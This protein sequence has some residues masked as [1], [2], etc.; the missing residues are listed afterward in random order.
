MTLAL[1]ALVAAM[2]SA[3]EPRRILLVAGGDSHGY[4]AH[5]HGAGFR[6]LAE[7]LNA[8]VPGLQATVAESWPQDSTLL[9][10][11]DALAFYG[12]GGAGSLV[13]SHLDELRRQVARG[14][15]VA[16][17]H[18]ALDVPGA[19][20]PGGL[21]EWSGGYYETHWSVN[22][23]WTA[24]FSTFPEHPVTRGVRPFALADE[25]YYNMRFVQNMTGV[26]PVLTALP[27]DSTRAG[28]DGPYSGNPAV[29]ARRGIPEHLAWVYER[30]DGGRSFG[31]TGGHSHWNWAQDDV[32]RLVLNALTWLAGVEVPAGGITSA[33]PSLDHLVA[34][35]R[36]PAPQ[37][38]DR[39]GV[40]RLLAQWRDPS[41]GSGKP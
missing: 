20:A 3:A 13:S 8:N 16:L 36:K 24:T 1:C 4:G 38:W 21:L 31:F 23:F 30:P 12:D 14:A 35:I 41:A 25:W 9:A 2:A 39:A 40:E 6:L 17:F 28:S 26:T 34:A 15:G 10:R 37:D 18:W 5:E 32:R 19:A 7:L 11:A 22:P 33:T 29:R 27:P